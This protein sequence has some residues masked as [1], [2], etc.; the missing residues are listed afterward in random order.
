MTTPTPMTK[1][2][3]VNICLSNMGQPKVTDLNATAIDAEIAADVI[4]EVS[5][6]VQDHG[7]HWNTEFHK[8]TPDANDNILV[9]ANAI[10]ID[11]AKSDVDV[12]VT[13]RGNK[14]FDLDRNSYEFDN[15]LELVFAVYLEF[16]K[17][18][19][20]AKRYIA[21]RAAR[22]FQERML[23]A[24]IMTQF[25]QRD[26]ERAWAAM[27]REDMKAADRNA[28]RDSNATAMIL[29]RGFYARGVFR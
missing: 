5:R 21:I 2:E 18:P 12:N 3:A 1:L 22:I 9:P 13:V 16:D 19:A 20:T 29:A 14:L 11:T 24:Q 6:E 26:E 15:G 25:I 23:G 28:I 4:D 8:L 27:V 17:L 10:R 7:W